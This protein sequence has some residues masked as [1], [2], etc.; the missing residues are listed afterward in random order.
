MITHSSGRPIHADR[1]NS[2]RIKWISV[3]P[4]MILRFIDKCT[5]HNRYVSFPKVKGLP[6]DAEAVAVGFDA[7]R[8]CFQ[9]FVEHPDWPELTPGH[10]APELEVEWEEE[11]QFPQQEAGSF[12][13]K[14]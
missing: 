13:P 10:V 1:R 11:D 4:E 5:R 9:V 8:R 12:E 3:P 6:E 14:R 2:T 7:R